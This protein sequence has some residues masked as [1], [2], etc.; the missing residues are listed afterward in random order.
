MTAC[1]APSSEPAAATRLG[2][3]PGEKFR[4]GE[5]VFRLAALIDRLPDAA[6]GGLSFGPRVLIAGAALARTGLL[7]P[8][9]LVNY[10]YR[11][12]LPEGGDADGLDRAGPRRLSAGRLAVCAAAPTRRR[13]WSDCSTGSGFFSSLAGITALLVGGIGIGNAVA[14]YIASKTEAIATL[15]CLGAS[16]GLVFAAYLLQILALALIGIAIGLML[17]GAA[18]L[19]AGPLLAGLLPASLPVAVYWGPLGFAALCGL[20]ATLVFALWPLAAIGR[21]PPGALWRDRIA[22]APRRLAPLAAA[23]T[24]RSPRWRWPRRSC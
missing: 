21:I 13:R 11:I 4:I 23:A 16:T 24:R 18:P 2:L 15:K 9:A 17:G 20:L 5:A 3:R 14:G 8:G 12:R 10:E 6:L 7:R 22:P 19:L 1:S